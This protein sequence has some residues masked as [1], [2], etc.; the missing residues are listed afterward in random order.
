MYLI[1]VN[2]CFHSVD[3]ATFS[4]LRLLGMLEPEHPHSS[5]HGDA[6]WWVPY[7]YAREALK[8]LRL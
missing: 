3:H 7:R 6:Y 5:Y 4:A 8:V 1:S 2:G